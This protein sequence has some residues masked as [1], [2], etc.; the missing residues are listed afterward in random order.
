MLILPETKRTNLPFPYKG[1]RLSKTIQCLYKPPL[2]CLCL[3]KHWFVLPVV[4]EEAYIF[5]LLLTVTSVAIFNLELRT[6]STLK[7][8][9]YYAIIALGYIPGR[10]KKNFAN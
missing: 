1:S 7:S 2:E 9:G 10:L 4:L 8:A 3:L 5:F 6:H